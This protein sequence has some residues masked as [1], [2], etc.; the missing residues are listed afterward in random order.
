MVLEV[1]A[2]V[3]GTIANITN[4]GLFVGLTDG[5]VGLVHI[6]EVSREYVSNLQS[7]FKVGQTVKVKILGTNEKGK[8]QLSIRAATQA[9]EIKRN[10]KKNFKVKTRTLGE[11][12]GNYRPLESLPFEEKLARY[13]KESEERLLDLKKN[14]EAKRGKGKVRF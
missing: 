7:L 9:P 10:A 3:E 1:G 13:M 14:V 8:L 12:E 4:Y 11:M 5:N 2:I 6:S